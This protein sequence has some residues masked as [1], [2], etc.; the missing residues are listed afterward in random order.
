MVWYGDVER[1]R[2]QWRLSQDECQSWT[3]RYAAGEH[4]TCEVCSTVGPV[5]LS[6]S[7]HV[8]DFSCGHIMELPARVDL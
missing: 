2:G 8:V 6:P 7:R 4:F 1:A 3:R 5:T